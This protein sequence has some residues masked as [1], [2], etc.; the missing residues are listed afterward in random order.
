S[1]IFSAGL[2][3]RARTGGPGPRHPRRVSRPPAQCRRRRTVV[4]LVVWSF[5]VALTP[6]V[7]GSAWKL[8]FGTLH[9]IALGPSRGF[10]DAEPWDP[11]RPLNFDPPSSCIAMAGR[12]SGPGTG[13]SWVPNQGRSC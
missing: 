3:G 6:V 5:V 9:W 7:L 4:N 11:P 13:R 1:P 12:T 8:V 2:L 10:Q